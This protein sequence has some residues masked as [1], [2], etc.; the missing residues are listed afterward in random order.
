MSQNIRAKAMALQKI[1]ETPFPASLFDL[2]V[3]FLQQCIGE[4]VSDELFELMK[5]EQCTESGKLLV[6]FSGYSCSMLVNKNLSKNMLNVQSVCEHIELIKKLLRFTKWKFLENGKLFN[7][8]H[9]HTIV[10]AWYEKR[11][12]IGYLYE[13]SSDYSCFGSFEDFEHAFRCNG[14]C[15]GTCSMCLIIE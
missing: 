9:K 6:K 10:V 5:F 4:N 12:N 3:L 11:W 15:E 1:E 13:M 8:Y 7:P 2:L 14:S